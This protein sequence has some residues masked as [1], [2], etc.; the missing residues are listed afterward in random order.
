MFNDFFSLNRVYNLEKC[1]RTGQATDDTIIRRTPF[2][3][4]ITKA[5]NT[6]SEYEI[7]IA[8]P[9]QQRLRKR[10]WTLHYTYIA[11]LLLLKKFPTPFSSFW[12]APFYCN[13]KGVFHFLFSFWYLSISKP[14]LSTFP[15]WSFAPTKFVCWH[16]AN[17]FL[18][19][20]FATVFNLRYV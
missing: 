19:D 14:F 5:T 6:R 15:V 12:T 11:C 16:N 2:A 10:P 3:C 4:W 13:I 1:C 17:E 7:L 20:I 9:L 18:S 8:F